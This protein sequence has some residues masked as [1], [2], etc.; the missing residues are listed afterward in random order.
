MIDFNRICASTNGRSPS[1]RNRTANLAAVTVLIAGFWLSHGQTA[2]A[3]GH[4][5]EEHPPAK[6]VE[7]KPPEP[8]PRPRPTEYPRG[9]TEKRKPGEAAPKPGFAP[10]AAVPAPPG[11]GEAPPTES[12]DP[13][14]MAEPAKIQ[15][16][17]TDAAKPA[18]GATTVPGA[19]E[20]ETDVA[21]KSKAWRRPTRY[22]FVV[23]AYT[24]LAMGGADPVQIFVNGQVTAGS[25]DFETDWGG[26]T[27]HFTNE[28][29][30]AA[31]Q[32]DPEV[33]APKFGGRCAFALSQG[34]LVEARPQLYLIFHEHLY[35]FANAGNRAAFL[36]NPDAYLQEAERQW[37]ILSRG[38]P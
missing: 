5:E 38:E 31:F 9:L 13:P 4:G 33:Y 11:H 17:P 7:A 15:P 24:G 29:N 36:T 1:W 35:L 22:H 20:G 30:L 28:G 21:A 32:H 27:W 19:T 25:R 10:V 18:E 12:H 2:V 26:A 37:P 14:P 8:P 34:L 3:A 6:A 16:M 23:D